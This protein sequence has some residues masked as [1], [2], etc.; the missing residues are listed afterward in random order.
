MLSRA[1]RIIAPMLVQV[2]GS[3]VAIIVASVVLGR[4]ICVLCGGPGRWWGAPAVGFAAL[5]IIAEATIELPGKGVTAAIVGGVAVVIAAAYLL[6]RGRPRFPV[7]GL[8]VGGLSLLGASVPFIA[9]G[10]IGPG[11]AVDN[12]L[13]LHLLWAEALRSSRMEHIWG[14]PNS[15]PLG[16]HAVVAALGTAIHA[17]LEMVFAGLLLASV[18]LIALVAADVLAG[19]ALWRRVVVGVT[20]SLTYLIAS[21]YGE[22]AF[23]ETIM[24]GLLLGFVLYLE[25]IKDRLGAAS[26]F[27]R[28]RLV[29][30]AGVLAA[31]AVYN[32][33][34]LG[35]VWFAA[36]LAVWAAAAVALRPALL[37]TWISRRRVVETAPW[38]VGFV[39]LGILVLL[40]IAGSLVN[41]FNTLG[42]S[43]SGSGA[44]PTNNLGN[45]SGPLS[46]YE[47]LGIWWSADFRAA[48]VNGFHAG[49][50]AAFALAA[51]V[52]GFFWS[53][54][55]REL[56]LPAAVAGAA[57]IYLYSERTQSPYVAAKAL[58]IGAPLVTALVL[59]ALLTRREGQRWGQA[60]ALAVAG[61]FAAGSGYSTY[62]ELQN[63]PVQA[64]AA[65]NE[66]AAF[67]R[68]TGDAPV[69]FLGIDDFAPWDLRESPV[70][71]LSTGS[72]TVGAAGARLNKPFASGDLDFDSVM[73]AD[74]NNFRYVITTN[75]QFASQPP[76]N[77]HLLA[78]ARLYQLWGR[79]G[80]T[81]P[82]GVIEPSGQPGAVLNCH[83]PFGRKLSR[84]RGV[85][86]L[87]VEPFET[88]GV[89]LAP[90]G[91]ATL[92]LPL[93]A[94]RWEVSVQYVSS[95][96]THYSM[97][98]HR[99]TLPAFMGRPSEIFGV[100]PVTG[101]GVTTPVVLTITAN[102]P[103]FLS[104]DT[105][106]A[107]A[108]VIFATRLPDTRQIVP[109]KDAC[110]KYVDWY[111]LT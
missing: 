20:C 59:R 7:G 77:F 95:M 32:Y 24:A 31:G 43:P 60:F 1:G 14:L 6:G 89:D 27:M 23:K 41:F 12:D 67:H 81:L 87:M 106:Y 83:S 3:A 49:Q 47:A 94:G 45:L 80:P 28:F 36:T 15:Y 35:L 100:G 101:Q 11:V 39:V 74:L 16:P 103:S 50:L 88:R 70:A 65:P 37:R 10:R 111:R 40:P 76:A 93:P 99:Y 79:T 98:G 56:V 18:C 5:M 110:G 82:R 107:D 55:R 73:P 34:Y 102:H 85:A 29:L 26:P 48:P 97:Q 105:T 13:A 38:V 19:Q 9:S 63:E 86:A 71:T 91:S 104:G 8:I 64:P 75:T 61:V 52:F 90:G 42:I 17:P 53:L 57:L 68:E 109:L 4:A 33:S 54:R 51:L 108:Q 92:G 84:S 78:S 58:V 96:I 22:G 21:Y 30:P 2:Y 66:L 62:R 69:L 44:V 72:Q 25:Q 46:P